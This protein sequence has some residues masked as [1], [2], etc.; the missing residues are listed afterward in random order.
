MYTKKDFG[1]EL[2][3]EINKNFNTIRI[4]RWA[5]EKY[6]DHCAELDK[7]TDSA[8]MTVI[9]MEEGEQFE[10]TKEELLKFA[11]DLQKSK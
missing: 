10:R 11:D 6:L 4:S 1:R 5:H 8:M 7:E 3:I 2:A 9:V